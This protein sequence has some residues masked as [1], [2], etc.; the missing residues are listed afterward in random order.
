MIRGGSH[1]ALATLALAVAVIGAVTLYR[2]QARNEATHALPREDV[3]VRPAA[4]AMPSPSRPA[5]VAANAPVHD[6]RAA[7]RGRVQAR[8][9]DAQATLAAR[10]RGEPVDPAWANAVE[11][12]LTMLSSSEQ[13]RAM[14]ADIRDVTVDCRTSTCRIAGDFDTI[15]Q[16]DD[17]FTLYMTNVAERVPLASYKYERT[18]DGA[19]R[20]VV[21][22]TARR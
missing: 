7:N 13:I 21:Y 2:M 3:A 4:P 5:F 15:T 12:E 19:W 20:I 11:H 16:G 22:A 1:A 17:W 6:A 8:V 9:D 14:H 18:P 10:H